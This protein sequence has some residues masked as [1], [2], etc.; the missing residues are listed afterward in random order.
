V[1]LF[2][3]HPLLRAGLRAAIEVDPNLRV[4]GETDRLSDAEFLVERFDAEVVLVDVDS[5]QTDSLEAVRKLRGSRDS[6]HMIM[7]GTAADE[8]DLLAALTAGASGYL[9]KDTS[10]DVLVRALHGL[11]A[12]EAALSRALMMKVVI[13]LQRSADLSGPEPEDPRLQ[14]LSA[15]ER[16]VLDLIAD[17]VPNREIAQRL[18]LSEHTV[19]N[20]V[21]A[22]L[23]KLRVRSRT[24]AAAVLR[25]APPRR[26][27]VEAA[28]RRP[29][30]YRK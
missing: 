29:L 11:R 27:D 21:K 8:D 6:L 14:E 28:A 30:S 24:A 12:G 4:V 22:V 9:T 17:G 5:Q 16:E 10:P 19:K 18:V 15:R 26:N 1:V 25:P 23:A 3:G 13:A 20:H 2:S 7:F